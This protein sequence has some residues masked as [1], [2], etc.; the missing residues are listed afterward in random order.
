MG[1]LTRAARGEDV[2][3]DEEKQITETYTKLFSKIGAEFVHRDDFVEILTEIFDILLE[4][5]FSN[6]DLLQKTGA[7]DRA[8]EYSAGAIPEDLINLDDNY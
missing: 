2:E 8:I 7:A 1:F 4:Y 3:P 5:D 6:I